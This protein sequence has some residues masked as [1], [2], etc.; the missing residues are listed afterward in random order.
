[1]TDTHSA[2]PVLQNLLDIENIKRLKHRYLRCLDGKEWD[3][4]TETLAPDV[5]AA[6]GKYVFDDREKLVRF[7][8][9]QMGREEMLTEHFSAHPE[10]TV[11]GDTAHAYWR[12]SDRVLIPTENVMLRGAAVYDDEYARDSD[13]AWRITRTGYERLYEY[14]I[15][16]EDLPSFTVTANRWG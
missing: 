16:L 7:M 1:M 9:K 2:D 6:Y 8:R 15:K 13:G 12:L 14:V 5:T 3:E 4:F 10:I 11:D